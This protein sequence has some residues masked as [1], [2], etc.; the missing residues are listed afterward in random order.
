MPLANIL[1][2]DDEIP[3]VGTMSKILRR[4]D[5]SVTVAFTAEEA[6]EQLEVLSG[7]EVLVLDVKM[8]GM[9]GITALKEIKR[10]YPLIE[11]ILLTGHATVETAVEGLKLGAFDSLMKPAE[12]QDLVE[13][14]RQAHQRK[15]DQE[16]RIHQA[17]HLQRTFLP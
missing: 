5:L 12:T 14:I 6:L 11:V 3:F 1:L 16:A 10:L 15:S 4:R 13:K 17:R 8:P 2:V 7:I 9:D